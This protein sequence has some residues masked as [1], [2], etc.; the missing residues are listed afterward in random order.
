LKKAPRPRP[1]T[2][3]PLRRDAVPWP[4]LYRLTL[5]LSSSLGNMTVMQ[6]K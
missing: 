4:T 3:S 6:V 2:N 1:H 5:Y